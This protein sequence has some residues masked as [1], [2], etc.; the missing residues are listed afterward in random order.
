[1]T[2]KDIERKFRNFVQQRGGLTYK[3]ISPGN[4]GVPDRIVISPDGEVWFVELKTVAGRL[5]EL[6]KWQIRKMANGGA[7]V[8][9]LWGWDAAANFVKEV[10]PVEV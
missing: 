8:R 3:F 9:V 6:Q 7:K 10:M 5:S 4:S 2:E 1:M